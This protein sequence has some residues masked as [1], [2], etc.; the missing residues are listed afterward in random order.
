[1]RGFSVITITF[2]VLLLVS[3]SVAQVSPTNSVSQNAGSA[4]YAASSASWG[5]KP[6][7]VVNCVAATNGTI[8]IWTQSNPPNIVLCNSGIY[9]AAPY[10]T[11]AIGILNPNPIAA[12]DVTGAT[13]T[14]LYYQI[15]G[16][17]VLGVGPPANYNLF[18]GRS[19]GTNNQ[20]QYNTFAG[21]TAGYNNTT[22]GYDTFAGATAGYNNTTGY[23]NT[24]AGGAAGYNNTTGS[25][26]T[27]TG[28][29]AGYTNTAGT[30]NTFTGSIA[31]D[32]NSTGSY[33]TFTGSGTGFANTT[34]YD[35]AFFGVHA[36]FTNTD[37]RDNTFV[38][39][40]AGEYSTGS[41]N[42]LI[43][44]RAGYYNMTGNYDLYIGNEGPMSGNESYTIR[45]GDP[46]VYTATYIAG[47]Y[48][49]TASGGVPVYINSNG[50][51]GTSGSALRFK[52]QIRNMGDSTD[53]LMKLR[54]V[55][56]FYKPEYD[57]GERTLQYGLIAEEVAKIYPELVAY[58]NDGRP[59]SVRYQYLTSMLL[60]EAQKQYRRAEAQA[61]V[62]KAQ[63]QRIDDLELRLYR[64]EE[65]AGSQRQ[66][67][68]Q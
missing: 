19:A 50:Q 47:I 39:T 56:F 14:S 7:T 5:V 33:N 54:P 30:D 24:F 45:L 31:G 36:G 10:G 32:S 61:E 9:E 51:L 62:I 17:M 3:I 68:A 18:V 4:R 26:N 64:L 35:N 58:D 55:T 25:N 11:G 2:V 15:G 44:S 22:G 46:V 27:F 21:A 65:M 8:P 38:G 63:E 16:A 57:K 23:F 12:L 67:V 53:A 29:Q 66:T 34:G 6:L 1:M 49:S 48:G 20:A 41:F 59:Y 60:N 37:G 52:E 43:G 13:N 40:D 42:T 28:N